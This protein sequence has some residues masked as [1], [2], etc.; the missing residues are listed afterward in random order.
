MMNMSQ[1]TKRA[2]VPGQVVYSVLYNRG[3][4]V[5]VAIQ[6]EQKPDSV[7]SISGVI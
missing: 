2:L 6:G 7:G 1:T 5:I 3:R 4:G